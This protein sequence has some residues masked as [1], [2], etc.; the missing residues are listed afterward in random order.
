[1]PDFLAAMPYWIAVA[2]LS[3]MG[4]A[5]GQMM[6]WL[7]RGVT[8][9]ALRQSRKNQRR[10]A[11]QRTGPLRRTMM[12]LDRG[13]ADPGIRALRR[14]GLVMV[15]ISYLTVG[16]QSMVQAGAGILRIEWWKYMIAQ[17]PGAFV[18]GLFY[19]T[20]GFLVWTYLFRQARTYPVHAAAVLLALLAALAVGWRYRR[21]HPR[22]ARCPVPGVSEAG[23]KEPQ[24]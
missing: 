8:E 6:Y 4:F 7:G 24:V 19:A 1:M 5:R 12:W 23:A 14:W 10:E 22:P 13:G 20:G 15:P 17:L 18:W 9:G 16:F 3:A 21:S 2:V 11:S